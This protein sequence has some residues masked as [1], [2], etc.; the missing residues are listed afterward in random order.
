M[1]SAIPYLSPAMTRN[2]KIARLPYTLRDELNQRLADGEP[3]KSL[4]AW[5]NNHPDVREVLDLHYGG[6]PV[7][8]QNLSEWKQGGYEDWLRHQENLELARNA[9][10]E[11]DEIQGPGEPVPLSD[12]VSAVMIAELL[13]LLRAAASGAHPDSPAV[14]RETLQIIREW[15]GIRAGDHRAARLRMDQRRWEEEQ[16]DLDDKAEKRAIWEN[17]HLLQRLQS[18]DAYVDAVTAGMS[19]AEAQKFR[20]F[21]NAG[22]GRQPPPL[23]PVPAADAP[24]GTPSPDTDASAASAPGNQTESNQIKPPAVAAGPGPAAPAEKDARNGAVSSR[25][26]PRP[27]HEAGKAQGR[28]VAGHPRATDI[29]LLPAGTAGR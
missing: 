21:V 18:R 10:G 9:A 3:E 27:L 13:R 4:V 26:G 16:A 20:Q 29:A 5:L 17:V 11:A 19:P 15:N 2:G 28:G 8:E 7:S 6:R 1:T 22:P 24:A 25:C 23:T 12:R 14:R